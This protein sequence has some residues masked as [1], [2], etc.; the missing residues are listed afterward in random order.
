[1]KALVYIITSFN[2]YLLSMD[3]A[4]HSVED[5]QGREDRRGP[6]FPGICWWDRCSISKRISSV[7]RL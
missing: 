7:C 5:I 1:M 2:K 3:S 4:V 6:W